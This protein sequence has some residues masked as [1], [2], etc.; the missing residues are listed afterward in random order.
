MK[1]RNNTALFAAIPESP[2]PIK[3][4]PVRT[5]YFLIVIGFASS[6]LYILIYKLLYID[7]PGRLFIPKHVAAS[8]QSGI[9]EQLHVKTGEIISEETSLAVIGEPQVRADLSDLLLKAKRDL[10]IQEGRLVVLD[11]R[12]SSRKAQLDSAIKAS[13]YARLMD[14]KPTPDAD[15]AL[16]REVTDLEAEKMGAQLQAQACREYVHGVTETL[17]ASA[18]L[19]VKS[20]QSGKIAGIYVSEGQYIHAGD[21]VARILPQGQ[22]GI[23][24]A[25]VQPEDLHKIRFGAPACVEI[26]STGGVQSINGYVSSMV[27]LAES[28]PDTLRKDYTPIGAGATVG[29]I[30]DATPEQEFWDRNDEMAINVRISKWRAWW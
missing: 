23:I 28:L 20:F 7:V 1:L 18:P 15:V 27:S 9:V 2:T 19:N 24:E 14:I 11:Q 8:H 10:Q 16:I 29:V 12:I 21:P 6:I 5:L 3:K 30:L 13:T 17:A 25:Y 4:F 22:M 26:P